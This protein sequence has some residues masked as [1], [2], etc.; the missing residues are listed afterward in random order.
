MFDSVAVSFI[1]YT[2]VIVGL[3]LYSARFAK[4]NGGR[5]LPRG[6]RPRRLGRRH[7]FLRLGRK[8]LGHAWDW[9]AWRT[10]PASAPFGSYVGTVAAFLFNWFV[11]A[12]RLR[13]R[14]AELEA[15][16]VPD[17]LATRRFAAW[18]PC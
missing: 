11:L 15:L 16:T 6:S 13:C 14:A 4:A 17:V 8:R 3:G 2:L 18:R 1:A 12:W 9:S 5:L 7:L 10:R